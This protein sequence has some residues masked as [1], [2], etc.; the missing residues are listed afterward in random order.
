[1][2]TRNEQ[3]V[4]QGA[5][6]GLPIYT[7]AK[8][9]GLGKSPKILRGRGIGDAVHKQFDSFR[10]L[11]DA[12]LSDLKEDVGPENFRNSVSYLR[13]IN[14]IKSAS[15]R[16]LKEEFAV[17]VGGDCSLVVGSVAGIKEKFTGKPGMLWM[18]AHGD[19][20]TPETS[21]SGYI[22][23]MC[24]AL[25]CGRGP[26]LSA[27]I[28]SSR[29]LL[30]EDALVHV[31]SR[32]LDQLEEKAMRDSEM[33]LLA[34]QTIHKQDIRAVAAEAAGFLADRSDWII[35]HLDLDVIDPREMPAVNFAEPDGLSSKAVLAIS[36]ALHS[37]GK[38]KALEVTS[39][40]PLND[41][42][43]KTGE[44]VVDL[45]SRICRHR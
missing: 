15:A 22:G 33:K 10:D 25:A 11:D 5:L 38:L 42:N 31:G 8:F 20:N 1:M 24:L 9:K 36:K 21:P 18:D 39:Y 7:L 3:S 34:S 2:Q 45:V 26:R 27:Q 37:T 44:M 32:A 14:V 6:I 13:D 30:H 12:K 17:I 41:V 16:F 40:N 23:G 35:L 28:E 43:G 4:R 29:P 19:F